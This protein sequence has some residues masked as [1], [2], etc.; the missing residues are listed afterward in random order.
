METAK[1]HSLWGP[2]APDP[3]PTWGGPPPFRNFCPPLPCWNSNFCAPLE[4]VPHS[5]VPA[6]PSCKLV[7]LVQKKLKSKKRKRKRSS[8]CQMPPPLTVWRPLLIL[9]FSDFFNVFRSIF[10]LRP[11]LRPLPL[12]APGGIAPPL[13]PPLWQG[14]WGPASPL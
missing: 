1:A 3:L 7:K 12:R 10:F 9:I 11:F 14:V 13:P 4:L 2:S 6:P 8:P 5:P